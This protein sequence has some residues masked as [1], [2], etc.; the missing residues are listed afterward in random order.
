MKQSI[1]S[2]AHEDDSELYCADT[3]G[4]ITPEDMID[5]QADHDEFLETAVSAQTYVNAIEESDDIVEDASDVAED[6]DDKLEQPE[7]VTADDVMVAQESMRIICHR[8]GIAPEAVLGRRLSHESASVNPVHNLR[9]ARE[10]VGEFINSVVDN[11]HILFTR[12][13]E[14]IKQLYAKA[15][16]FLSRTEKVATKL[17]AKVADYGEAP[18]DAKF[19]D[20]EISK[21]SNHLGAVILIE[22]GKLG[23]D[24]VSS[25]NN[26]ITLLQDTKTISTFTKVLKDIRIFHLDVHLSNHDDFYRVRKDNLELTNKLKNNTYLPILNKAVSVTADNN[27][28][29]INGESKY[30]KSEK[31]ILMPFAINGR[32]IYAFEFDGFVKLKRIIITM[33][34]TAIKYIN[35][36]VPS[37]ASIIKLLGL[38]A[39][40]AS[41]SKEFESFAIKEVNDADKMLSNLAKEAIKNKIQN[42]SKHILI[43]Y[44]H[45]VRIVTS[46]LAVDTILAQVNG[47]KSI[48]TYCAMAAKKFTKSDKK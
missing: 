12:L 8:Y 7:K 23:K 33:A 16:V 13:I 25:L 47:T 34:P 15:V 19:D 26:Y 30:T 46:N 21:I 18:T 2:L 41:K 1:Y 10:G 45:G 43:N 22:G 4:E 42:S 48:L 37:K 39:N 31:S 3:S 40:T 20:A 24:P 36:D 5:S 28:F 32:N 27:K 17:A 29:I 9:L 6:I 14:S 11:V 35:V 38:V 44:I